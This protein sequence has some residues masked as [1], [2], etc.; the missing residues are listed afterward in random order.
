MALGSGIVF[1]SRVGAQTTVIPSV[2]LSEKYDSN[3]FRTTISSIP[4]GRQKWDFITVAGVTVAVANKSRLGNSNLWARVDGNAFVY[5][6]DMSFYST[7]VFAS[8]DLTQGVSELVRGLKLRISDSFRYTP[9]APAFLTGGHPDDTADVYSRGI[10]GVR[11]NTYKNVLLANSDYSL[12]RSFSLTTNYAYSI[13]R[14]GNID[15]TVTSVTPVAYF[16]NTN[17][18]VDFGPTYMF[19][20]GDTLY[21]KYNYVAGES[22]S[23]D[24]GE[25]TN[26][27]FQTLAPVYVTKAVVPGWTLTM[28]GGATLVEQAGNRA[29]MSGKLGLATD[30]ERRTHVQ[31]WVSRQP[32]PSFFGTSSA[33]ISNVAQFT[34]SHGLSRLLRMT[35]SGYYGY[36]ETTPVKTYASRTVRGTVALDYSLTQSTMLSLSQDYNYYEYTGALPFDRIVTMLTLRT[37]WQ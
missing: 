12:T 31:M 36:N 24:T 28:S 34:V 22:K 37:E 25:T 13:F 32:N 20:G 27:V 16:N 5:N 19:D 33:L 9:E 10:Q 3:I 23:E 18:S 35:V 29:F 17:H 30:I 6:S 4:P 15:A 8:S 21:I 11:A 2:S 14:R 7:N 1:A 26:Y